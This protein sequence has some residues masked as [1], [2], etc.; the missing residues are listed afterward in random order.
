MSSD[1]RNSKVYD[2]TPDKTL[3][4]SLQYTNLGKSKINNDALK[5]DYRDN[6]IF[7]LQMSI[8]FKKL[9]WDG[10]ASF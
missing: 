9:P 2:W 4:V 10:K 3:G 1:R 7:F 6:N 5:G 8:N